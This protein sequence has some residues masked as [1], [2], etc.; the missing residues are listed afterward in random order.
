MSDLS[1]AE[2]TW[3]TIDIVA[4]RSVAW[5]SVELVSADIWNT[6]HPG[7]TAEPSVYKMVIND[8]PPRAKSASKPAN[9]WAIS[10]ALVSK[11]PAHR[12]CDVGNGMRDGHDEPG[13]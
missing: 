8:L 12:G 11:L 2:A 3:D 13:V 7:G 6:T 5:L 9:R 10:V 1:L 4:V